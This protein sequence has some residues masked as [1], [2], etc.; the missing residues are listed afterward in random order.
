MKQSPKQV[1]ITPSPYTTLLY[2]L[3]NDLS[4]LENSAYFFTRVGRW[5]EEEKAKTREVLPNSYFVK[6]TGLTI[7]FRNNEVLQKFYTALQLAVKRSIPYLWLRW[8]KNFRW[9]FLKTADIWCYD[10]YSVIKALIGSRDYVFLDE[11]LFTYENAEL[12]AG[13]ASFLR[14]LQ[15]FLEAPFGV[16]G[17]ATTKQAKRIILTGLE[18]T[19][20]CYLD[21]NLEVVSMQE[22]WEKSDAAKRAFIMKFF[23]LTP[24]D[25]EAMKGRDVI[26]VEQPLAE[27]GLITLDEQVEMLRKIIADY[28]ASRILL[29][30]HYRSTTNYRE[31][32]PEVYVWDKSTPMEL[33]TLCGVRFNEAVTVN[34]TA[35]LSFPENVRI[36]WLA[37]DMKSK[38]FSHLSPG[39]R[40]NMEVIENSSIPYRVRRNA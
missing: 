22:L 1:L 3:A 28:G 39:S 12:Y 20:K 11:G 31:L 7:R 8:T 25:V 33:L 4:T 34:S 6:Q 2:F 35:V 26:L 18:E 17:L 36:N 38:Y 24:E 14:R 19:P 27:G 37:E 29:K 30:T 40:R 15:I 9:P 13:K 32:F 23:T 21:R 10:N 16:K 5:S